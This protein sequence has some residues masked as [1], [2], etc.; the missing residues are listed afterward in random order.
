V[1]GYGCSA[2][3]GDVIQAH[4]RA[5]S[6]SGSAKPAVPAAPKLGSG[7]PYRRGVAVRR[8]ESQAWLDQG[9]RSVSLDEIRWL[10][11]N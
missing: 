5:T 11:I 3:G 9:Q 4:L 2:T 7:Q 6:V 1:A 8:P 10:V